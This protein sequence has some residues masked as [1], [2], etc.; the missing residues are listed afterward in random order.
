MTSFRTSPLVAL[1]LAASAATG[2]AQGG[3]CTVD[4]NRPGQVK[5]AWNTALTSELAG[6]P[7]DKKKALVRA[8]GLL[9][10]DMKRF[11]SNMMGRDLALGRVLI[12][13]SALEGMP[14]V[15]RRGDIGYTENPDGMVDLVL[16]ADTALD[17]V[18]AKG[19][20][21]QAETE[22]VRRKAYA[23]LVN[24][25]VNQYNQHNIDSAETVARR[26]IEVYGNYPLTYIALNVLGNAQQTQDD[27]A[28][29]IK[30]FRRMVDLMKADTSLTE[31]RKTNALLVASLMTSE[32]E[33]LEGDA[34]KAA[35]AEVV[36]YLE[37]YLKEF[38]GDVQAQSAEARAQL[39]SGDAAT[40]KKLFDDMSANPDKYTDIQLFEAGVGAS[41]A[42]LNESAA[43]LFEEGLKKNPYSRDGLF[44]L[45]AVY[46]NLGQTDKLPA[47][48]NRLVAIDPENPDNYQL[49]ARYYQARA[50]ALKPAADA[51]TDPAADAAWQAANDSLF[52]SFSRYSDAPVRVSFSLFSHD[53]RDKGHHTLAGT[54]ENRTDQ[55]KSYTLKIDFMDASGTV[56]DS[57]EVPV[58]SVDAKGSKSFKVEVTD[59]PGIV[60]FKYAPFPQ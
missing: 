56:L 37:D 20:A 58:D 7:D 41:R 35:M 22:E 14:Q 43:K 24:D 50:K 29:A 11:E 49:W 23:P 10:K 19:V 57:R 8:V 55:P 17:A 48:L 36:S 52:K 26:A 40:A 53:S 54:I 15:A 38:P 32:G 18:D 31:E 39:L 45:A 33:K 42:E 59:K 51:K 3:E 9:T 46:D 1:L 25:A 28:G 60:A 47:V 21:C 16:A 13:L 2:L 6:R 5:D 4:V 34:R 27:N 12:D 30:S 44:N